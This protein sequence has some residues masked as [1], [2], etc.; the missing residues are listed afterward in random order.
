M[1]YEATPGRVRRVAAVRGSEALRAAARIGISTRVGVLLVAIFA[2]LSFGP[3]SG[4]LARE[5]ALKFD[6]PELTH[7]L[8]DPLLAPL[9]RWDSV[10]YLRI[11]DG[12]YGDDPA[13][14]AFFPLYPLLVRGVGALLGGSEGALLIAAYLISL[15]AFLGALH[16]LYRLVALELGRP[17]ARPALLLLAVFPAALYFGAPYSESLFLLLAVGTF[18]AARTDHWAWA[19][20]CAGLASATRS[21]GLLLLIP[22][23]I[24]WWSSRPRRARDAAWLLLAPAGLLGYAAW[25]GLAEGDALRFLDVQDAW[26]RELERAAGGRL[27]GPR[28]RRRRRASARLGLA[29]AGVLRGGGRR[30]VPDRRDQRDAV[31]DARLRGD[32][33]RRRVAAAAARVRRLGGRLA[34]PAAHVPGH[35]AAA[36]VAAALR[37]GPVPGLHVARRRL[38]GAPDHRRRGRGVR[39]RPRALHRAVRELALDLVTP[40]RAVL[41]DALGT[42][43][44]L[45][46]PAP[47]LQRVLREAGFAVSEEQALRGFMAE[48]EYYLE[49]HLDGSDRERLERLRDRCAE[50]LRR[51]LGIAELDHATARRALLGSLEFTAYEDVLPALGELRDRGLHAW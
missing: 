7:A 12:G 10:W 21:A 6:Q 44:E 36:H 23:L 2:A 46:P 5:N 9:A 20:V 24:L 42:L 41:L 49:H 17:L 35:A 51:G 47:R 34:P 38:R 26:A 29:H 22:L 48:I 50:E 19:G 37:G 15:A 45:Q 28:R 40:V 16:L 31:R 43:V 3:A 4:G 25:L 30:P 27:G 11:A 18:Y 33:L 1:A 13:R 8:A 14:A 39:A 32:R